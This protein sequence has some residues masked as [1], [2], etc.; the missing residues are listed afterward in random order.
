MTKDLSDGF[1]G[2]EAREDFVEGEVLFNEGFHVGVGETGAGRG[3]FPVCGLLA[4]VPSVSSSRERRTGKNRHT[5]IV[6]ECT[7]NLSLIIATSF[8]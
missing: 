5:S 1:G 4:V 2:E 6:L 7:T 8:A 3:V